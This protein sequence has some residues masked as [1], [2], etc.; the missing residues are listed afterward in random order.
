MAR[1]QDCNKFTGQEAGDPEVNSIE[2]DEDGHIT[3]DVRIVV[4]CA[5][6]GTEMKSADLSLEG[7]MNP[8]ILAK[9]QGED[10]ELEAEEESSEAIDEYQTTDAKGKPIKNMRYQKHL[11][12]ARLEVSV[13]CSCS[14]EVIDTVTLEDSVPSSQMDESQ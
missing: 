2:I 7:D 6:C 12:G 8:E 13:T 9:H 3:A 14:K 4:N 1:C 11:Y 5:D 10:H